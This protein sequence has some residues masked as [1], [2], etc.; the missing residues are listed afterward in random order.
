[1]R[2]LRMVL[3]L[4][5]GLIFLA[6]GWA[7]P[8]WAAPATWVIAVPT[9]DRYARS[10]NDSFGDLYGGLTHGRFRRG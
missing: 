4:F 10:Y 5:L 9:G 2:R 1:M 7:A 3:P 8:A 6:S